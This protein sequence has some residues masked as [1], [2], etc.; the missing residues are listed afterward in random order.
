M[1]IMNVW[2]YILSTFEQ[3]CTESHIE[4]ITTYFFDKYENEFV[5]NQMRAHI[6]D[7]NIVL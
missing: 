5:F 2:M 3:K 6:N 7:V 1:V 4:I